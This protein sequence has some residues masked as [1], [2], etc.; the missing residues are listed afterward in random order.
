[1]IFFVSFLFFVSIMCSHFNRYVVHLIVALVCISLMSNDIPYT[2][3]PFVHHWCNGHELGQTLGDG[4]GQGGLV[5]YSPWGCKFGHDWATEQQ[6]LVKCVFKTFALLLLSFESS[7]YILV[8][9][10]LL[11]CFLPLCNLSFDPLTVF[12]RA[13]VLNFNDVQLISFSFPVSCF[14]YQ[15]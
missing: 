14:W 15:V 10:P 3:L 2:Y 1:M 12:P 4:E 9:R 7:F 8:P 6:S 5:C 11:H 13:K